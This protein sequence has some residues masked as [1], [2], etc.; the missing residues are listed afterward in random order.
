MRQE[1]LNQ[2]LQKELILKM[3]ELDE[4]DASKEGVLKITV[5]QG[6][7]EEFIEGLKKMIVDQGYEVTKTSKQ[8][9][10]YYYIYYK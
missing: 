1:E 7:E 2:K 5:R 4:I 10:T 8:E 9:G 3:K 6:N